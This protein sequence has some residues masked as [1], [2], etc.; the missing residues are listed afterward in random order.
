MTTDT[1]YEPFHVNLRV[2]IAALWASTM[3]VVVFVDL[4]SLYRPDVRADIEAGEISGFTINQGFLLGTTAYVA[5]PC[6]MIFLSLVLRPH[7][8]RITNIV[9]AGVYALTIV[10]GAIGDWNY[11]IL[12]SAIETLQLAAIVYY[13]WTWPRVSTPARVVE[14]A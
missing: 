2:K 1:T 7:A 13:C 6:L 3:F 14:L 5:I 11:Y 9:L 4:F 10:G 12:G 8:S